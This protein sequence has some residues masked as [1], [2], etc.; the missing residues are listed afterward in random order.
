M[1]QEERL[2]ESI[3]NKR[4]VESTELF[5]YLITNKALT[6]LESF[7]RDQAKKLFNKNRE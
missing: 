6:K 2:I 5:N 4:K 1:T 7:K 3:I